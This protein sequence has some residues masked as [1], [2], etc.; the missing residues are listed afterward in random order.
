M[1]N[2]FFNLSVC[3]LLNFSLFSQEITSKEQS[4]ALP[5]GD[6]LVYKKPKIADVVNK[7]PKNFVNTA[8]NFVSKQVYPYTIGAVATTLALLP[9]DPWLISESR[10]LGETLGFNEQHTYKK[11]ALLENI[12]ADVNSALYLVGNGST[13][14]LI[15]GGLATYGLIKNDYRAQSTAM[16]LLE[17]IVLT[18]MFIQPMKRLT[19]RE[20]PFITAENERIHSHWTFAPSFS[21]YQKRTSSYDAMPS[22]HLA[23]AMAALTVLTENY[24]EKKW[25]KPV[26]YS[27]LGLMCYEMMQSKVHWA[28]DYPMAILVGYLVGK[29]IAKQRV[30]RKKNVQETSQKYKIDVVASSV[31]NFNL[32][33]LKIQF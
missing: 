25:L 5:N 27:L 7:L 3:F 30:I 32:V 17:S 19:G 33:G 18:G 24:P 20:S 8:E 15:S 23:T 22:G 21:A 28:S 12:P 26:G 16:Q 13:V 14:I 31:N 11:F 2:I 9:A 6:T 1:K 10:N 4:Y 29:N